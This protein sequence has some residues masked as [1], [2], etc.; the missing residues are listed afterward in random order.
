MT[1]TRAAILSYKFR[2]YSLRIDGFVL[3]LADA[4]KL[5]EEKI[6]KKS[7]KNILYYDD[8]NKNKLLINTKRQIAMNEIAYR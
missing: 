8:E 4:E 6:Y 5:N 3:F 7:G 2:N 1:N